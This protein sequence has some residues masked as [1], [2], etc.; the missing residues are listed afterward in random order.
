V[1]QRI[2]VVIGQMCLHVGDL[3]FEHDGLRQSS[4]FRYSEE[5]LESE[6]GSPFLHDMN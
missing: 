5:W 2:R 3:V 6:Y 1:K 4:A